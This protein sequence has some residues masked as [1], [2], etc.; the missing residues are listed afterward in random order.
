MSGQPSN[1]FDASLESAREEG[2]IDAGDE[3]AIVRGL[4]DRQAAVEAWLAK[5]TPEYKERVERD[6]QAPADE[7]LADSAR[8][9]G[10]QH[11]AETRQLLSTIGT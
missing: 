3:N 9:L 8:A 10:Q 7:W 2:L 6:G 4:A 1:D 11:G 5:I